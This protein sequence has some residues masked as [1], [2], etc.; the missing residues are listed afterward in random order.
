M[1][2]GD[3][4]LFVLSDGK[5]KLDGG[6]MFGVVPKVLWE[7][8]NPPNEMNRIEM[9]LNSLLI[10]TNDDIVLVDTGIGENYNEKFFEMFEIDKSTSLL[11]SLNSISLKPDD[12]TKVVLTHLHFDHCGGNC[13]KDENG[14]LKPTFP[15]ATYYFQ[16]DEFEY[17]KKPDPRSRGSYLAQNWQAIEESDQ[18]QLISGN[19]EIIPGVE[20]FTTGGHTQNHQIVKVHS[21]G[22]TACFLADLVPTDSHLKTAYV[23]GYDL[24]PKTT[25]EMK[26]KVL[27]QALQ[28][29]WLLIF[30]H[31]PSVK[32]GYLTEKEGKL[33]IEEVEI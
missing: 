7:K 1:K 17:A 27:K 10:K 18:V 26:E 3:F 23:M 32:G 30:E 20:V 6:A 14:E 25:M 9:G 11:K 5:F 15:N 29:N 8:T 33:R 4:E 22:K 13:S 24:Y 12:I 31:A 21:D 19:Q 28:E 2:F 16:Q